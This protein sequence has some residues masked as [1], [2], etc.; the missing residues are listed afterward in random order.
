MSLYKINVGRILS[1]CYVVCKYHN[2]FNGISPVI[3]IIETNHIY[4]VLYVRC[5]I[6]FKASPVP[7][8]GFWNPFVRIVIDLEVAFIPVIQV[9]YGKFQS[10]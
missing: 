5:D 10:V 2:V 1:Y 4:S 3:G 6:V 7:I 8:T 9:I